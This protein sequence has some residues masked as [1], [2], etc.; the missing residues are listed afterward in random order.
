MRVVA[1]LLVV[2][3]AYLLIFVVA[4][5]GAGRAGHR[6][7]AYPAAIYPPASSWPKWGPPGGCASLAGV[8]R[9]GPSAASAA[10]A[11]V[12]HLGGS[13]ANERRYS[14]RA[15]WPVLNESYTPSTR[16]QFSNSSV[17]VDVVG[18]AVKSPYARLVRHWCGSKIVR[19]SE[20]VVVGPGPSRPALDTEYWLIARRGHWLIWFSNP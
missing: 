2:G 6:A 5:A 7:N 1:A 10:V 12:R 3:A 18:P 16:T 15:Y 20:R 13:L 14:D 11:A 17:R 9:P 8:Q 19:L 4:S